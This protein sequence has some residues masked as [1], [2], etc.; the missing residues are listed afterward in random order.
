MKKQLVLRWTIYA[1]GMV[2]LALGII[3]T[4]KALLGVSPIVSIPYVVS[5]L[6]GKNFGDLTLIHYGLLVVLQFIIRGKKYQLKDLLQ[7][8]VSLIFTRFMNLFI[9]Y[10]AIV[11]E[12][13]WQKVLVLICGIV[14]TGIGLSMSVIMDLVPNPGD[15]IVQ[16]LSWRIN[17]PIGTC[18]NIIDISSVCITL[19]IGLVT[20]NFLYGIGLGTIIAMILTGRVVAVFNHFC[21][22]G[23]LKAA[24]LDKK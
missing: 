16:A 15:G 17:K 12:Q 14:L 2:I 19:I 7:L 8:I 3:I 20:K 9:A 21:R 6:I 5:Y 18:K 22:A 10:I 1:A 24:G 4:S 13:L 11:P 23:L